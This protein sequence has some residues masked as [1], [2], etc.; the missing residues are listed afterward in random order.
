[1]LADQNPHKK[2]HGTYMAVLSMLRAKTKLKK[3][4]QTVRGA[5]N[6]RHKILVEYRKMFFSQGD[7]QNPNN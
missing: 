4:C 7:L 5:N 2:D 3:Y 1:M 6:D